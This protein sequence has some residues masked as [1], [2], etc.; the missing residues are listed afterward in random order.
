MFRVHTSS[1]IGGTTT[2][3][4]V[5]YDSEESGP[6]S[7]HEDSGTSA[8]VLGSTENLQPEDDKATASDE[9]YE[10]TMQSPKDSSSDPQK[11]GAGFFGG[12]TNSG[13]SGSR[14]SLSPEDDGHISSEPEEPEVEEETLKKLQDG[15]TVVD[16]TGLPFKYIAQIDW[17]RVRST[18]FRFGDGKEVLSKDFFRRESWGWYGRHRVFKALSDGAE[19]KWILGAWVPSLR[20]NDASKTPIAQFHRRRLGL[21][22]KKAPAYLEIYPQGEHMVDEIFTTFIYIEK[23]RKE[24]ERAARNA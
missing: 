24:K 14:I 5:V 9:E 13:G 12:R 3:T 6:A 19:Y 8:R 1:F 7:S 22:S 11:L 4:K 17:R 21:F 23:I 18:K 2:I 15:K 20:T 10:L 16:A